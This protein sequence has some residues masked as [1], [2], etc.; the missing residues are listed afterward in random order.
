LNWTIFVFYR[1]HFDPEIINFFGKDIPLACC[2]AY[3]DKLS[4]IILTKGKHG[5]GFVGISMGKSY[6]FILKT[7]D[8]EYSI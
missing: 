1:D 4:E 5:T 2:D 6:G 8:N 7:K 3:K